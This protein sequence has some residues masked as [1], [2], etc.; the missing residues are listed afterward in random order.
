MVL[1]NLYAWKSTYNSSTPFFFKC[2]FSVLLFSFTYLL[3]C[4]SC[5]HLMHLNSTQKREKKKTKSKKTRAT[6]LNN[7]ITLQSNTASSKGA[8]STLTYKIYTFHLNIFISL[9]PFCFL[10]AYHFLL[11][12]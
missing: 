9:C 4:S 6:H 5:I 10:T 2:G 1:K 8:M 12:V 7:I 11:R 3:R